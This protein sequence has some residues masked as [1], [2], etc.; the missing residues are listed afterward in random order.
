MA[1]SLMERTLDVVGDRGSLSILRAGGMVDVSY[2]SR[3]CENSDAGFARRAFVSIRLNKK[4]LSLSV[5]VEGR[6][7][8]K[9]FCVL[10]ARP[11]FHTA[12]VKSR[13]APDE[14]I[15]SGFPLRTD[16]AAPSGSLHPAACRL[17]NL[18]PRRPTDPVLRDDGQRD[19]RGNARTDVVAADL[20]RRAV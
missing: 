2:G 16:I 6:K 19:R 15:F 5:T 11:R 1:S 9:Q 17:D 12:W 13:K 10:S 7:E 14:H 18:D 20:L 8:R 3:L 4:K